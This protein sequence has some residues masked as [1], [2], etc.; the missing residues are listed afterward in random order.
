[1]IGMKRP[2][3]IT[4]YFNVLLRCYNLEINKVLRNS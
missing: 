1:M 2:Q 3:D 4:L